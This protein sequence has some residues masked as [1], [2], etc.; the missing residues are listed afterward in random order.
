MASFSLFPSPSPEASADENDDARD[1][2]DDASSSNDN[3]MTT[4][5]W[6]ALCHSW[7]KGGVVLILRVV[8]YLEGE[9]V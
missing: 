1:D 4:S 5:Q 8:L 3:K 6:L 2:E 9:L 7:Q